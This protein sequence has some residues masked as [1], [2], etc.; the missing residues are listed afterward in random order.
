VGDCFAKGAGRLGLELDAELVGWASMPLIA[1][2]TW[3]SLRRL[4][5]RLD[6]DPS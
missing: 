4:R 2:I 3:V 6:L 5:R 1:V